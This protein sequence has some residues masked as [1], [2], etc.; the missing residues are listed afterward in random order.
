MTV[1]TERS[2]PRKG[3]F[4]YSNFQDGSE[5]HPGRKLQEDIRGEDEHADVRM[6]RENEV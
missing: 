1:V 3:I 6:R 5:S 2:P 4:R